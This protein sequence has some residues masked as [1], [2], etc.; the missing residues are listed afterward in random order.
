MA[1]GLRSGDRVLVRRTRRPRRGQVALL[2]YPRLP[3]GAPTGVDAAQTRR[4]G[5]RRPHAAELGRPGRPRPR[6]HGGA[7]RLHRRP[8]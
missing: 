4:G 3:S 8:G 6:R 2:R 1:P 5:I 7:A